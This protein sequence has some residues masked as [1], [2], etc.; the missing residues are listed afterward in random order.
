M[1]LVADHHEE[2][3]PE[4]SDCEHA[5]GAR[6]IERLRRRPAN[7]AVPVPLPMVLP[8]MEASGSRTQRPWSHWEVEISNASNMPDIICRPRAI[9]CDGHFLAISERTLHLH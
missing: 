7:Y 6:A 4:V 5:C 9:D 8:A 2:L 1:R 3:T